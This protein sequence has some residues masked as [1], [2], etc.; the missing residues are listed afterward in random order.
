MKVRISPIIGALFLLSASGLAVARDTVLHLPLADVL[1][2]PEAQAQLDGSVKFFLAGADHP[3]VQKKVGTD[4]TNKKTNGVGKPDDV[5]CRWVALSALIALQ[6]SAKQRGANA[7][8]NL[9]SYYK[10]R[11]YESST[12]YECH[13]GAVIVGVAL[14][15][16][17]AVI[18]N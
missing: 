17:Y 4:V 6:Q 2:M 15:G 14:K 18:A 3:P 7:V 8:V 11:P 9:A 16:D 13:A 12:D 5:A 10:K 1:A